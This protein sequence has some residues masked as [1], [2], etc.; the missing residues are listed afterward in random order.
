MPK[1]TLDKLYLTGSTLKISSVMVRTFD[2]SKWEVMDIRP[3]YSC[4]LGRPWIHAP[5]Q[6]LPPFTKGSNS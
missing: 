5:G 2:G 4:H 1:A 6:F 3:A